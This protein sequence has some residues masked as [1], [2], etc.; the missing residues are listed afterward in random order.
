MIAEMNH[1]IIKIQLSEIQ[2][3][4]ENF[5]EADEKVL[6]SIHHDENENKNEKFND[7]TIANFNEKKNFELMQTFKKALQLLTLSS[8]ESAFHIQLSVK[9][10][11]QN[12]KQF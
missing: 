12:Q 8:S 3:M 4:N 9:S 10:N 1:L 6:K 7:E 11:N 2:I 5:L